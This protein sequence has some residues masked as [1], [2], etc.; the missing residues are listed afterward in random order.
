MAGGVSPRL[1]RQTTRPDDAGALHPARRRRAQR[2]RWPRQ[3]GNDGRTRVG[4][5]GDAAPVESGSAGATDEGDDHPGEAAALREALARERERA[6]RA[7]A[8]AAAMPEL[9]ER[10]GR[11]E[12]ETA[13]LREQ[14]KAE[15]D[16]ATAAE[17][18]ME[19]LREALAEARRP[20]WRRWLG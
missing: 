11:A 20:F 4:V 7:E 10:L 2:E 6:D 18:G 19:G 9:R 3:L 17:A 12:G 14:V 15:R 1:A 16:R 5:P 8:A 13:A